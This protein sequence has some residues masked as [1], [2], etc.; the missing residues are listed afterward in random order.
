MRT[1]RLIVLLVVGLGFLS[2]S[3][4][5]NSPEK[6]KDKAQKP[7]I[8]YILA[9]DLGYGHLGCYGQEK[10]ETP[11]IDTLAANGM[12]FTQHYAGAALCAPSRCVLL[13]GKHLGHAQIRGNDD[14]EERGD[15]W[16]WTKTENTPELEGQYPLKAGTPTIA[17]V[18]KAEGY[19]TAIIGKWGL[20]GPTSEGAPNKQGFDF[21]YG[22]NCQCLAHNYYPKYLWRGTTKVWLDNHIV[23]PGTKYKKV[24]LPE[25]ADPY[26]ENNYKQYSSNEYAPTLMQKE[27]I[28]FIK[29]NKDKLFFLYY[30]STIPHTALQAPKRLIDYYHEKFGDE[31]PYLGERNYY[32]V[33]Y[34]HATFAAMVS[35]LDEQVGEL[36]AELKELGLYE[37]TLIIITGDNGPANMGGADPVY[38]DSA[39]PFKCA[40]GWGKGNLTEGGIRV[41]MIAHWPGK[42]KAGSNTDLVSAFYDVLPTLCDVAQ[43][44]VPEGGDGIS[45]LPTLL[46]EG[47]QKE[48]EYMVWDFPAGNG[49]QAVRLGT[50][51][52]LRKKIFKDSLRVRLYNLDEDLQETSD[53]SI[54]HPE[55]VRQMETIL[56]QE[57]TVPENEHFKMK[58]LGD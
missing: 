53:I 15:V 41:P 6:E 42:I 30:A 34:P 3:C 55:L 19:K 8:I 50:W 23:D 20:G 52:A 27:A 46:D 36:V 1:V 45:F 5:N 32:P 25:G 38:F 21:F 43:I 39:K 13:T 54:Q 18:L 48:H 10:I 16:N 44:D 58:A 47:E 17:S 35:Y 57:H 24:T 26:D 56:K 11:N 29:A 9:D 37:N 33:R 14:W 31:E 51:K 28:S 7:N 12:I 22:Y 40:P 49:Q 4:K 2:S